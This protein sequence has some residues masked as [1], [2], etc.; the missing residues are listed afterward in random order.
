M[1]L[2]TALFFSVTSVGCIASTEAPTFPPDKEVLRLEVAAIGFISEPSRIAEFLREVKALPN[3]WRR[4]FDT[5]PTPRATVGLV[6]S[7]GRPLCVVWLGP[8]WLGSR[9]G[10]PEAARPLLVHLTPAQARYFRDFVGGK[11]DIK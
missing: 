2:L 5:F 4:P 3:N 1:R 6:D 7:T 8:N 11:W 10:L 9:C